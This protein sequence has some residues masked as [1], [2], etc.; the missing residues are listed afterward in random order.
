MTI[1]IAN[2]KNA[3]TKDTILVFLQELSKFSTHIPQSL[4]KASHHKPH[5]VIIPNPVHCVWAIQQWESLTGLTPYNLQYRTPNC[6]VSFGFPGLSVTKNPSATGQTSA[7]ALLDFPIHSVLIGHGERRQ[8]QHETIHDIQTQLQQV[9]DKQE[10]G[11]NL[12]PILC[13]GEPKH[14]QESGQSIP[15]IA[16]ELEQTLS[17]LCWTAN[18]TAAQQPK[19][20]IQVAI[21]YEPIWAIGTGVL[22][23]PEYIQNIIDC[24]QTV[25]QKYPIAVQYFYGGSVQHSNMASLLELNL[26]GFLLGKSSWDWGSFVAMLSV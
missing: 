2:W 19:P 13:I 15:Y 14:I 18:Q 23:T 4:T 3:Q 26:D 12:M 9:I 8:Y 22:P 21:A 7:V 1:Y 16:A 20:S 24:I 11:C 5:I 10:S 25:C 17:G 6:V